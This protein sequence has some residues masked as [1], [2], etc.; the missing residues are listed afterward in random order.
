MFSDIL[1]I[2]GSRRIGILFKFSCSYSVTLI[3]D[4]LCF[5]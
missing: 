1:N 2:R 3:L 5:Y 4:F